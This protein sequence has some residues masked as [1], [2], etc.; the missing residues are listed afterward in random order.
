MITF[1]LICYNVY[2][3]VV[4]MIGGYLVVLVCVLGMLGEGD[5]AQMLVV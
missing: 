2:V 5:S 4:E 3:G 1:S